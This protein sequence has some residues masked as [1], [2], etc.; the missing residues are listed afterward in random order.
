MVVMYYTKGSSKLTSTKRKELIL[1]LCRALYVLKSPKEVADAITDLLTPK[2]V[3]TIAKRLEIAE[4]LV[5]GI[6]YSTIR[7]DLNTV[8]YLR[9]IIIKFGKNLLRSLE[10]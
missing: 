7:K 5:K 3:E 1:N 6:D 2:E 10:K 9:R 4:D 8:L